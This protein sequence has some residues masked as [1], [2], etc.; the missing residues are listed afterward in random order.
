MQR[1]IRL[2]GIEIEGATENLKILPPKDVMGR[3][4]QLFQV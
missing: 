3:V 2:A 4:V 1:Y